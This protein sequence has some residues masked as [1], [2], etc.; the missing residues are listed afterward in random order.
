MKQK[1]EIIIRWGFLILCCLVL[2]AGSV[3]LLNQKEA[4]YLDEYY[5]YGCANSLDSKYMSF[6]SGVTYTGEELK[7][8]EQDA[9]MAGEGNCYRFGKLWLHMS[10]NVHP[11]VFYAMLHLVCSLTPGVFSVW[12]AGAVNILFALVSMF[13]FWK[14]CGMLFRGEWLPGLLCLCWVCTQGMYANTLLLRDYAAGTCAVVAVTYEIL[15]YLRGR[16]G[17]RDLVKICLASAFCA[18]THYYC[19]IWLFFLC[20]VLCV[21]LM[22]RRAWKAVAGI[23]ASEAVAAGLAIA[24]FPS[25]IRQLLSSNRGTKAAEDL[26]SIDISGYI[27]SVGYYY[28]TLNKSFFGGLLP[29]LGILILAAAAVSLLLGKKNRQAL[30]VDDNHEIGGGEYCLLAFP[31]VGFFLMVCKISPFLTGRYIYPATPVIFLLIP[32]FLYLMGRRLPKPRITAIALIAVMAVSCILSWTTG[33]F[34]TFYRGNREKISTLEKY[35]GIDAVEIWD[36]IKGICSVV[37]PQ[38]EY[39]NSVTFYYKQKDE[40]LA[41]IPVLS[42]GRDAMVLVGGHPEVLLNRVRELY[43]DY[44]V[45]EL[46]NLDDQK[47]FYN[48]YFH[49]EEQAENEENQ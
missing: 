36:N 9:F 18:L 43:P 20:A 11:P 31:S 21:I 33:N 15:L 4:F 14:L 35:R 5:S 16:R 12:Q 32:G 22:T 1:K 48:Y 27:K 30:A 29:W 6:K 37:L 10:N 41:E 34:Q 3:I 24:I 47:R 26:T 23:F 7:Q 25:M 45:T 49:K 40:A 28:R 44:S 2:I 42:E 17:I 8:M 38:H 46:G 39:Y 13:F 19:L